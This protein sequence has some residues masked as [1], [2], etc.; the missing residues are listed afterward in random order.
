M[1]AKAKKARVEDRHMRV[2]AERERD[3]TKKRT[4]LCGVQERVTE[5]TAVE[6]ED[7]DPGLL[8]LP[9]G[10]TP[11]SPSSSSSTPFSSVGDHDT[12]ASDATC[13]DHPSSSTSTGESDDSEPEEEQ[14]E[15]EEDPYV[16]R[17]DWFKGATFEHVSHMF[18]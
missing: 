7:L 13:D 2:A 4:L 11:D 3:E 6:V 14:A 10:R 1:L 16:T 8:C 15:E 5:N 17:R 12:G 9:R 18:G